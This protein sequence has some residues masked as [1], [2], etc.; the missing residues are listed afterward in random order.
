MPKNDDVT[1]IRR[2][3]RIVPIKKKGGKSGL[4]RTLRRVAIA[5][6]GS[7]LASE[8]IRESKRRGAKFA[9]T[10]AGIGIG[11][12]LLKKKKGGKATVAAAAVGA[13]IGSLI[14]GEGP[15][16]RKLKAIK[17]KFE[18]E[19]RRFNDSSP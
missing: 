10:G 4:Q 3:G 15:K 13:A 19:R 5:K 6:E 9:A 7:K 2:D 1:F 11:I 8:K 16:Q 17:R 12:S 18:E 14:S